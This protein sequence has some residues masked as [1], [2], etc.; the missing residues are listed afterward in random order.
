MVTDTYRSAM[1][2]LIGQR[3]E[4]VWK[5]IPRAIDENDAE[6]VHDVRVASRRLRA[7]MDVSASVFPAAWFAPLHKAAKEITSELGAVR[8]RDVL[9]EYLTAARNEAP[10]NEQ[11]GIGCLIVRIERERGAA[12]VEMETYLQRLISEGLPAETRR[13]FPTERS[14]SKNT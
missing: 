7:A 10:P 11:P 8:D 5:T 1:R 12:R 14:G 9:I 3:W 2:Q 6:G 13:R 4:D